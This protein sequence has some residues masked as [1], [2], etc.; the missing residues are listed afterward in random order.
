MY[1]NPSGVNTLEIYPAQVQPIQDPAAN[2][3][4]SVQNSVPNYHDNQRDY[5]DALSKHLHER[6]RATPSDNY[7]RMK[8]AY[9]DHDNIFQANNEGMLRNRSIVDATGNKMSLQQR[10]QLINSQHPATRINRLGTLEDQ[11]RRPTSEIQNALP[12]S[13]VLKHLRTPVPARNSHDEY[14][15]VVSEQNLPGIHSRLAKRKQQHFTSKP[16][17]WG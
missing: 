17:W 16:E 7:S 15:A 13:P 10:I 3:G 8:K 12:R 9:P 6:S 4:P 1:Q 14:S 5:H 11:V 2:M